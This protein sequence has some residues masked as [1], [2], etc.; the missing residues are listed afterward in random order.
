MFPPEY[1]SPTPSAA[2]YYS[3]EVTKTFLI[4]TDNQDRK[5]RGFSIGLLRDVNPQ[6]EAE[7]SACRCDSW[8]ESRNISLAKCCSLFEGGDVEKFCEIGPNFWSHNHLLFYFIFG[9]FQ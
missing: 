1:S 5:A 8:I 2:L 4:V 3:A 6:I 7:W 9:W